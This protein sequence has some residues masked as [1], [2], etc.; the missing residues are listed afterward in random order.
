VAVICVGLTTVWFV[1]FTYSIP[2][3]MDREVGIQL[4]GLLV[5]MNPV[6]VIVIFV[7]TPAVHVAGCTDV[8]VSIG[9][10]LNAH[11]VI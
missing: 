10:T 4:F 2:A 5:G 8:G 11:G 1:I 6:P 9:V 3:A 7:A